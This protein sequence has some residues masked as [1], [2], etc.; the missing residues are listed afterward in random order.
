M[1]NF[2]TKHSSLITKGLVAIG[3]FAAPL[4]MH[5][6]GFG[7]GMIMPVGTITN[8]TTAFTDYFFPTL[9]ATIFQVQ[10]ISIVVA[11]AAV[12]IMWRIIKAIFNSIRHPGR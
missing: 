10:V 3:A 7:S 9:L 8:V 11:V 6:A 2:L 12:Y 4:S 5:A 1:K